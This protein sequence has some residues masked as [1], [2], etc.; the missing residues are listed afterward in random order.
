M[1]PVHPDTIKKLSGNKLR[2]QFVQL[3]AGIP[4]HFQLLFKPNFLCTL[5]VRAGAVINS[6]NIGA[7]FL[8]AVPLVADVQVSAYLPEKQDD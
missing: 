7:N 3:H 1:T 4:F 2:P 6:I 8:R 5:R